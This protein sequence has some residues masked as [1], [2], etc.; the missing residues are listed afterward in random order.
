MDDKGTSSGVA[1]VEDN[2]PAPEAAAGRFARL[3]PDVL[4][5]SKYVKNELLTHCMRSTTRA[6][7][8]RKARGVLKTSLVRRLGEAE[9][10]SIGGWKDEEDGPSSPFVSV[11]DEPPVCRW[12]GSNDTAQD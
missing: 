6:R 12:K 8:T 9:K 5:C 4:V 3:F 10:I 1:G 11:D 7:R 2:P